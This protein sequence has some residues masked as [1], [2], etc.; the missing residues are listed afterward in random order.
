MEQCG[1]RTAMNVRLQSV[2]GRY[3]AAED[4]V[5]QYFSRRGAE[6]L[7]VPL[8]EITSSCGVSPATVVRVC[9]HMGYA[10]LK[11]YRI[12]L[13]QGKAS[14]EPHGREP[15]PQGSARLSNLARGLCRHAERGRG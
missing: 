2:Q 6:I 4:R 11:D 7:S 8:A 5:I 13:A 14:E 1:V 3:G 10:G 9:Q 15:C 12:A